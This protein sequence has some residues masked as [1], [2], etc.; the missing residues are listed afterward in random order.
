MAFCKAYN[1]ALAMQERKQV[2]KNLWCGVWR[3]VFTRSP[4]LFRQLV[5]GS[6]LRLQQRFCLRKL[7]HLTWNFCWVCFFII[8]YSHKKSLVWIYC[9][10]YNHK[11]IIQKL[12]YD[13]SI[14]KHIFKKE[15]KIQKTRLTTQKKYFLHS[16]FLM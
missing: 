10:N 16:K 15:S 3:Q 9:R 2:F 4:F 14:Q 5:M 12:F 7:H 8:Y 11:Y 6:A 1:I 13:I